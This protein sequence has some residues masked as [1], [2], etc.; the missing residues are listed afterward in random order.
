VPPR[1]PK[2]AKNG[3]SLVTITQEMGDDPMQVMKQPLG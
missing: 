3:I 1:D 2:L